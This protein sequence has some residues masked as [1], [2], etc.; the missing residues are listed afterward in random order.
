[1]SEETLETEEGKRHQASNDKRDGESLHT[2]G[3]PA[4]RQP[5]SNARHNENGNSESY[6]TARP[7]NN[8]FQ[9]II[10]LSDIEDADTQNRTVGS[11]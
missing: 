10:I 4:K 1:M 6:S 9:Q 2:F 11:D 7:V 5:L 3:N 8:G